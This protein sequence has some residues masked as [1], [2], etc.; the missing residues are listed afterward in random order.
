MRAVKRDSSLTGS[1]LIATPAL[2]GSVFER[3][4]IYLCNHNKDHAMGIVINYPLNHISMS[5]ILSQLGIPCDIRA[6]AGQGII[7]KG[8]PMDSE[9]GFVIHSDDF[10][11]DGATLHASNGICMTGTKEILEAIARHEGPKKAI[12]A[13]GHAGWSGDQLERELKDTA[14][15]CAPAD[16]A[17][18]FGSNSEEKWLTSL[19]NLGVD[20]AWFTSQTG[21]A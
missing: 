13:L 7:V 18:L 20:P 6:D 2:H 19:T 3:S 12:L 11:I 4:V 14:W 15:L 16:P 8:G 5:E 21:H 10:K 17:F 1:L 9:R